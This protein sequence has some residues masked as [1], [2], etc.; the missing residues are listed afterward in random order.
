MILQLSG[1]QRMASFAFGLGATQGVLGILLFE[2]QARIWFPPGLLIIAGYHFSKRC[3]RDGPCCFFFLTCCFIKSIQ[4]VHVC[5]MFQCVV[6]T[7][8]FDLLTRERTYW[9][10]MEEVERKKWN[11]V[12]DDLFFP[13]QGR[14]TWWIRAPHLTPHVSWKAREKTLRTFWY[15]FREVHGT[16]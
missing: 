9:K 12:L 5:N 1:W 3:L 14:G 10:K 4:S 7:N 6:T 11:C 16:F 2:W 8:L 13:D 15:T